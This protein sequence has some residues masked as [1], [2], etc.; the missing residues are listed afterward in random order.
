[1]STITESYKQAELALA[2][3]SNLTP[4][5]S[6][7]P[8][9]DALEANG[10]GMTATQ[11]SAFAA[12]WNVVTQN[13]DASGLSATVFQEIATGKKY[14]AIRGTEL[15]DPGD[16]VAAGIILSG[17][18]PLDLAAQYILLKTQVQTWLSDSTL[19]PGF[20]VS[21]HSLGGYLA[22]GLEADLGASIGQAYLYNAPGLNG[23][24]GSGTALI[25]EAFGITAPVDPSKILNIKADAGISL[26]AGLGAQVAPTIPFHIENQFLSDVSDPPLSLNHSQRVLTDALALYAM[27]ARIDPAASVESITEII[28]A[29]SAQNGNTLETS[30]DALRTLF[31]QNYQYGQ[32]DYGAV[33]TP[34][35]DSVAGR[36]DYYA[37]LQS[38][39]TW[40]EASPF[41]ATGLRIQ[42][43]AEYSG[44]QIA[45]LAF[46]DTA[47]GQ[48]YRYALYKLNPFAVTGSTVLY[49]GINAHGELNRYN[50]ATGSGNLTDQYLKDRAAMLSWKLQ[51]GTNDTEPV[52]DTYVQ[53]QSGTP[54]YFE[55]ITSSAITTKMRI[56]GGDSVN[57]VMSRPLGD[58]NLITFGSE[59]NDVLTGQGKADRLYGGAGDDTLTGNG[60]SD[61]LEGGQGLRHLRDQPRRRLRHRA[62]QRRAGGDQVRRNRSPRQHRD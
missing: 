20:S 44:P 16:I 36:N 32:L 26:I 1:M 4:G 58:F 47:D 31:Q 6:G 9:I 40:W 52:G 57:A 50:P 43:L 11:A 22:V 13:N 21:G 12:E 53:P 46:A 33:P 27:F 35:G 62:R 24:L 37:N 41:E 39:Q 29:S 51:F 45:A 48:A 19:T 2:A 59:N 34:T 14:L 18:I 23:V 17:F 56:G 5:I 7:Q 49:D 55:D 3:Y 8:Y 25:L 28:K 15:D 61:Y 38:L 30:L 10:N 54:F 60:G 42:S